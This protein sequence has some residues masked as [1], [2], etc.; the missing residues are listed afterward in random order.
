VCDSVG[1]SAP[2]PSPAARDKLGRG[3]ERQTRQTFPTHTATTPTADTTHPPVPLDHHALAPMCVLRGQKESCVV[4]ARRNGVL[5]RADGW[6]C[7][8]RETP[9]RA[10]AAM[11]GLA[12]GT[13]DGHSV[14]YRDT[15]AEVEGAGELGGRSG[16]SCRSP[17]ELR[18]RGTRRG[19]TERVRGSEGTTP[20]CAGEEK[21]E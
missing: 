7:G 4:V 2:H 1:H 15:G 14:R 17:Q 11:A 8:S 13:R 20:L 5:C 21:G 18:K 6:M 19:S 9:G 12:Q 3:R 16:E 10:G